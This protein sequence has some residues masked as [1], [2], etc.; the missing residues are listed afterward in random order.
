MLLARIRQFS[1]FLLAVLLLIAFTRLPAFA[2]DDVFF[3]A[4]ND[5]MLPLA[6][7]TMP[8]VAGGTLYLAST[9]FDGTDLG[10]YYSRSREKNTVML[11][12]HR[13][14]VLFDLAAGTIETNDGQIYAGSAV[15]RG[16][17]VFLPT[18]MVCRFLGLD[19]SLSHVTHGY[20]LRLR[21]ET[22][23]LSDA[24]FIDAAGSAMSARYARY[25]R[26]RTDSAALP[27]PTESF[28]ENTGAP[29]QSPELRTVQLIIR[30]TDP[31]QTKRLLTYFEIGQA[32]CLFT[33][34]TI[35]EAGDLLR[36]L[37][38]GQGTTA[39]WIDATEDADSVLA[40]IEASNRALWTVANRKTRLVWLNGAS[41]ATTRAV[42]EAGYCPIRV[43]LNL[44]GKK[45]S[46]ARMS[47][48]ILAAA[49]RRKGDC[50]VFLGTD[51][52]M[53]GKLAALL[54]A[55]RTENCAN[56]PLNEVTM[57]RGQLASF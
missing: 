55:L 10:V 9:V 53:L 45:L 54:A 1:S 41:E 3:T 34:D 40:Q 17:V 37:A 48:Q 24:N 19:Y 29:S 35:Q 51:T 25:V 20:L 16:D 22:A 13:N 26:A 2:V 33:L 39:L 6:N 30:S 49:N 31:R 7:E 52:E 38:A 4:V 5:T 42:T 8:F 47:A 12:R 36:R 44:N 18:D 11:Y 28:P 50:P 56:T 15:T 14:A 32:T 43:A 21:S 23:V 27:Q 46:T 57:S